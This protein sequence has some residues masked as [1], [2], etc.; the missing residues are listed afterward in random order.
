MEKNKYE[1]I[2]MLD[3]E[4]KVDDILDIYIDVLYHTSKT[5]GVIANKEIAEYICDTL[6]KNDVMS[7]KEIDLIDYIGINVYL[8]SV[9]DNGYI[10]CVPIEE[11]CQ[12]DYTDVFYIDMDGE[13]KQ[14]IIDYC[15]NEDK[16]VILFGQR[17]DDEDYDC[18]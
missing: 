12:L 17:D 1:D 18:C 9:N 16:K 10:T 3:L 11:Y 7:V 6:I 8:V 4:D 5:V 14:D 2:E 13:I 15:V